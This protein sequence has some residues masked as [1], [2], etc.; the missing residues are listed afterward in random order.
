MKS[1]S[2]AYIKKMY[3]L[4]NHKYFIGLGSRFKKDFS[5]QN[6]FTAF[7]LKMKSRT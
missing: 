3:I 1:K 5:K 6:E 2:I 4:A 7:H